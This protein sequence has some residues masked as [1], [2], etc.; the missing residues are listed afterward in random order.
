MLLLQV[1]MKTMWGSR[2]LLAKAATQTTKM[3]AARETQM[4]RLSQVKEMAP[5]RWKPS[6]SQTVPLNFHWTG[7]VLVVCYCLLLRWN[8]LAEWCED[9]SEN[10]CVT[11][12]SNEK[13][14]KLTLSSLYE[15][16]KLS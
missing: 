15:A 3:L 10:E 6:E 9:S 4:A 16:D 11:F 13:Q 1:A 5:E 8:W 14:N 7:D 2:R 12:H